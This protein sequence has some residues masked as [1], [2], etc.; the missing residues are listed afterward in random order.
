MLCAHAL[1]SHPPGCRLGWDR[2]RM[3]TGR[4]LLCLPQPEAARSHLETCRWAASPVHCG[5]VGLLGRDSPLPLTE[6]FGKRETWSWASGL[7]V[8]TRERE[9]IGK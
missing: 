1:L 7:V 2:A 6:G 8:V 9:S 3:G 4:R 5:S